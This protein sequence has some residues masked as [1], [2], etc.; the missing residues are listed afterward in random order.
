MRHHTTLRYVDAIARHGSIRRAAE[1]LAITPSAL[2]RRLLALEDELGAPLFERRARGVRL[3]AAGE[4]F[5]H[6]ARQQIA[7]MDRVRATIEDMKGARR[8]HVSIA[9][10]NSLSPR[11]LSSLLAEHRAEHAGVTFAVRGCDR[12]GASALLDDYTADLVLAIE[13]QRA[14][15]LAT[16]ATASV[17]L[18]ALVQADDPFAAFDRL[19]LHELLTRPLLLPP[20]ARSARFI[21]DVAVARRDTMVM[22]IIE[23]DAPMLRSVVERGG[24]VALVARVSA[25]GE[26]KGAVRLQDGLFAV[27]LHEAD[28]PPAVL[29]LG[30]LRDR[31]L[32]VPSARFAET[33]A[34]RMAE[35]AGEAF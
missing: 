32:P 6:H 35:L 26:A 5:V 21:F 7:D 13:P 11:G 16:I 17:T 12:N 9:L 24:G 20:P 23:G 22:P 14:G 15:T 28:V 3:A 10:D 30:Q 34:R 29:H 33:L 18:H 25:T 31:A 19:R 8:G 4:L 1:T 2:N 27:P